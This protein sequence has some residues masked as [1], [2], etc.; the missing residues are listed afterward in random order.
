MIVEGVAETATATAAEVDAYERKYGY[1]PK[2]KPGEGW[3]RVVP[4]RALAWREETY[5]RSATRFDFSA[6]SA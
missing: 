1:R 2:Q 6:G 4:E 3:Y 5:P